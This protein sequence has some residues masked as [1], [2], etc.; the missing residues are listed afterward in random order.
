MEMKKQLLIVNNI[1]SQAYAECQKQGFEDITV[2]TKPNKYVHN[3]KDFVTQSKR[4]SKP[5]QLYRLMRQHKHTHINYPSM[6]WVILAVRLHNCFN[7]KGTYSLHYH[8]TDIRPNTLFNRLSRSLW[9]KAQHI[10]Y[11]TQDLQELLPKR[12]IHKPVEPITYTKN[13]KRGGTTR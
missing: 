9:S 3:H 5:L 12:A 2:L 1:V 11:S 4:L 8:G 7:Q 13:K 10:Y 6:W